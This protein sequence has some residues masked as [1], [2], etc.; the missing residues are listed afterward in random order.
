MTPNELLRALAQIRPAAE[1]LEIIRAQIA[2]VQQARLR[3]MV[4][5][6]TRYRRDHRGCGTNAAHRGARRPPTGLS[7]PTAA[8]AVHRADRR[9]MAP[10]PC[11][12]G[13]FPS[14]IRTAAR[15][16]GGTLV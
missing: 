4:C 5:T 1:T 12:L 14:S 6:I 10:W 13:Q 16:F 2:D 3:W 7:T 9:S 11:L 15:G 8:T